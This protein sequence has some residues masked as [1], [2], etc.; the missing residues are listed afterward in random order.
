MGERERF[1]QREKGDELRRRPTDTGRERGRQMQT[2]KQKKIYRQI[3][4]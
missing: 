4:A 3:N 2:D 1:T